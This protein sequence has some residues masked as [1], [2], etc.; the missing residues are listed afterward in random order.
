[1]GFFSR[2]ARGE[3]KLHRLEAFSDGVFAIIVT[4]LVLELRVPEL[5]NPASVGEL[6]RDLLR[7]WPKFLS[8]LISFL[9]L[10]KF[11]LNLTTF[12]DSRATPTT[13][14]SGSTRSFSV[15]GACP[16]PDGD[17][18]RIRGQSL[19]VSFFGCV[20]AVNTVVFIVLHAHIV[21]N[22]IRPELAGTEAPG[23]VV[24][25]L[26]GPASYLLGAA[27]TWLDV[28]LA[29]LLYVLTPLFY[30]VPPASRARAR[31]ATEAA[32]P[33]GDR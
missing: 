18:G 7:I 26:V 14:W 25:S 10:C 20:L 1:M 33:S 27:S 11:W 8:W 24:R 12:W 30:L 3:L 16:V 22:L 19:A 13:R 15:S 32:A 4:P 29:F 9:I 6:A 31:S 5:E 23:F 28:R 17:D 21:R 2:L